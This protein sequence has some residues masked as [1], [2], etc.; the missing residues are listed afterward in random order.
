MTLTDL[1]RAWLERQNF[2]SAK[3]LKEKFL[4]D[5]QS[6]RQNSQTMDSKMG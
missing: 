2:T 3:E 4:T 5:F 6:L 1:A